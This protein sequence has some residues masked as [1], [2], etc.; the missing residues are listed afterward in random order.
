MTDFTSLGL[1]YVGEA[2]LS[3]PDYSFDLVGI[4]KNDDGFYLGTDS[5]CSCP[6]PWENYGALSDFTGPL[7]KEQAIEEATN[8]W[9]GQREY[10]PAQFANFIESINQA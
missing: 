2:D 9:K 5:G 10:D 6:T 4:W 1:T 3:E 8:L 7:T